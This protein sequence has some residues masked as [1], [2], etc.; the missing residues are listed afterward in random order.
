MNFFTMKIFS[1]LL[2]VSENSRM[3]SFVE[4]NFIYEHF[5]YMEFYKNRQTVNDSFWNMTS[6]DNTSYL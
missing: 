6:L 1:M 4:A 2:A 3:G 5:P